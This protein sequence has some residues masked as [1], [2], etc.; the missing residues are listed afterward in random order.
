MKTI[1]QTSWGEQY[2]VADPSEVAAFVAYLNRQH[3]A[4][5]LEVHLVRDF[6]RNAAIAAVGRMEEIPCQP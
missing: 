6:D 3:A 4:P 2:T 5:I 1:V